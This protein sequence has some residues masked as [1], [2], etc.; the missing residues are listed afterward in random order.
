MSRSARWQSALQIATRF[1]ISTKLVMKL[2][3]NGELPMKKINGQWYAKINDVAAFLRECTVGEYP[4][5]RILKLS[6]PDTIIKR[7]GCYGLTID[8][9][10]K[11]RKKDSPQFP[12]AQIGDRIC[13]FPNYFEKLYGYGPYAGSGQD[14]EEEQQ[15]LFD[16]MP[17]DEKL[18]PEIE[19]EQEQCDQEEERDVSANQKK[20]RPTVAFRLAPEIMSRLKRH[21]LVMQIA[22]KD[23]DVTLSD[24]AAMAFKYYLD[25][26]EAEIRKAALAALGD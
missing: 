11:D 24:V 9:L 17:Q 21:W 22:V 5:T 18:E 3:D 4:G 10:R 8:A 16:D 14:A 25:R 1:D 7:F 23:K 12:Y 6:R 26:N 19:T 20:D 13:Y 15:G 2:K